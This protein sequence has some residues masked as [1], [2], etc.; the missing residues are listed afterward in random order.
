MVVFF[1]S[2]GT[3]IE[4]VEFDRLKVELWCKYVYNW[5][6]LELIEHRRVESRET[7][8]LWWLVCVSGSLGKS[9]I[10]S[11]FLCFEGLF[12]HAVSSWPIT[13]AARSKAWTVF[14]RSNTGVVSS[15]PTQGMD[16]C[17]RLFC[18]CVVL[19]VGSGLPRPD[20]PS[21][22]SYRVWIWLRNWKIDQGPWGCGAIERKWERGSVARL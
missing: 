19:C 4:Q 6:I 8:V 13:V 11:Y 16:V 15:N 1:I 2:R 3:V 14:A 18:V 5:R 22:E 20:P 12:Y 9:E 17:V 21:K 10:Y 7:S